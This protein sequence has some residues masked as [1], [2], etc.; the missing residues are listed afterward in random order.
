MPVLLR[1]LISEMFSGNGLSYLDRFKIFLVTVLNFIY[2]AS[3]IDI[4]PEEILGLF[5][6]KDDL[7]L[8]VST[9]VYL[10]TFYRH[11]LETRARV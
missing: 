7:I 6:Y 1:H 9:L 3:P 5:G 10:S 2:F 8:V 4:F 11:I